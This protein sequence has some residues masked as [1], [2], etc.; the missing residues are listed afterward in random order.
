MTRQER[1]AERRTEW[2][3]RWDSQRNIR[4]AYDVETRE[5]RSVVKRSRIKPKA[6]GFNG[7]VRLLATVG[8]NH[9]AEKLHAWLTY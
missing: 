3:T 9:K 5:V 2:A 6:G 8:G 7:P 4:N 1:R